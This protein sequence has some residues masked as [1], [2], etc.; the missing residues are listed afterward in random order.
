MAMRRR[1][2]AAAGLGCLA[3][4]LAVPVA[5]G[6]GVMSARAATPLC[7]SM[8]G[9]APHITKVLWIAMENESYG[10]DS[11]DIPGSPSAPYIKNSLVSQCGSTTNY[12]ALTHPSYPN[13]L[14][15]TSGSTQGVTGDT[16]G[17]FNAPSIFSQADPSWR[18]YEE[19]MP[20]GCDHT[21][22]TGTNPPSQ[23]YVGRH[24]PA[25]SYSALP[26]GAPSSG[27]CPTDDEPL[28]TTTTGAL[29]HDVTSGALPQFSFVT[30]GLCDDMHAVPTGDTS[31]PDLIKG[32]DNWLSTWIPLL[33][34]G[35]D[36]TSG[37]LLIDV[38]WDEGRG[39]SN[40]EACLNSSA[41]DCI[42]PNLVISPYTTN[43]VSPLNLSH[44][45]LL[46]T[47]EEILGLPLLGGAADPATND[48]CSG[49]GICPAPDTPPTASFTSSCTGLSCSFDG[50]GSSAP[51][52]TVTSYSWDFS[53]GGSATTATPGH[54]FAGTGSYPVTLTVTNADGLTDSVTNQVDVSASPPPSIG[55]V[56]A[57][58]VTKNS[59]S[60]SVTVPTSVAAGNAMVLVATG[61]TTGALA[62][63]A[64][65]TLVA[66][67][68]NT[69]TS[70]VV[71]SR[72]ATASDPGS[73]V[74][75]TFPATVKGSVQ[76]AAYSGT[77]ASN[78]VA[79]ISTAATHTNAT[80]A[81]TPSLAIPAAGDWL[82]S[83]WGAKSSAITAWTSPAGATA[84]NAA[85]G[86]GGGQ[87]SSLLSDSAGPMPA[88]PAGGLQASTDQQFSASATISLALAP[89]P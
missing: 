53:D 31:C 75:V 41:V 73:S 44:Y 81:T 69:V 20:T 70:T 17:F 61:V 39:G 11:K 13:Y 85:I 10:T 32:G 84:R 30:P 19:F 12:H 74:K 1:L 21:F 7:G 37:N 86:T 79:A 36:Y 68:P 28:G 89:G 55:F 34:S 4:A 64:G 78:P 59:T 40:G 29:Q 72:V 57:T 35:P 25:A 52:S 16:L 54:T 33:T 83:Y 58:G 46:K 2:L 18:S 62:A 66:S 9:T 76:L 80:V 87:I 56:A 42:V 67:Q 60:E 48:M 15:M 82:L 6:V 24:N 50:T 38:V 22:R 43:A 45:S 27:D 77:S 3:L 49:F 23:Y 63:P 71:W 14:A 51:G 65:W 26:V 88:A 8:A 47:T 5:S